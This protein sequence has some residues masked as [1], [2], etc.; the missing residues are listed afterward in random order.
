[1][2]FRSRSR[3]VAGH[4]RKAGPSSC[5]WGRWHSVEIALQKLRRSTSMVVD[6][7]EKIRQGMRRRM[8]GDVAGL[9]RESASRAKPLTRHS[10]Y[11]P[12]QLNSRPQFHRVTYCPSYPSFFIF[13]VHTRET[14]R[15][16]LFKRRRHARG[17]DAYQSHAHDGC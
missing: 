7:I 6:S 14:I 4:P 11:S 13:A 2:S 10:G 5:V 9:S 16:S 8:S 12:A 1:M 15:Q 3:R 17:Q